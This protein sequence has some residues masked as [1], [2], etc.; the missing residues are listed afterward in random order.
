MRVNI[1]DLSESGLSLTFEEDP[2][3]FPALGEIVDKN[4]YTF[5]VPFHVQILMRRIGDLVEGEGRLDTRIR[6][7]CSRCLKPYETPLASEFTLTFIQKTPEGGNSPRQG[8]IELTSEEIGLIP[9]SGDE[10]DLR[11]AIQ[12]EVVM[13]LPMRAV[14]HENCK[15]LCPHCGADLNLGDCGCDWKFVNPQFAVLKG[16]KLG[17]K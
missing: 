17:K 2:N 7:A 14:C 6:L 3:L 12:E 1:D 13:V 10:I 9:F 15:G 11:E 4:E 5:L 16:L 8:E